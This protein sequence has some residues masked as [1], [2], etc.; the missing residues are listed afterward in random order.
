[1]AVA[2]NSVFEVM[3]GY[4]VNGQQCRNYIHFRNGDNI[5]GRDG[6]EV[7]EAFTI[8][9]LSGPSVTNFLD[10]LQTLQSGNVIINKTSCQMVFP[11]RWRKTDATPAMQGLKASE[12]EAQNVQAAVEKWGRLAQRNNVG[13]F[14]VGGLPHD[15]YA[16]GLL[17]AGL[18]GELETLAANWLSEKSLTID[19]VDYDFFPCILN[20]TTVIVGGIPVTTITGSTQVFGWAVKEELRTQRSRTFRLGE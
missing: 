13:G 17:T 19:A 5:V 3:V 11:V 2:P 15:S 9:F 10:N 12:C 8:K 6:D 14:R 7:A 4:L 18:K 20:K 1:M 16:N